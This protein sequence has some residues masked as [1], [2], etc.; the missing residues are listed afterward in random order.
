[1]SGTPI[2]AKATAVWLCDNTTMTFKQI[3]D[4][5]ALHELEVQGIADGDVAVGVKGFDPIANKQLTQDEI[6]RGEANPSHKLELLFHP[7]SSGEEKRRGPRYTPLSKRQDRPASIYWLVKFHPELSDGQISKLV[8]TTKPTIQAI[9]ERTH[10]NINNIEPI[11]PVALGLCK[12]VELDAAVQKAAAKK[13]KEGGVM[14]DDERRKLVSTE[15]SL[16]G[17]TEPKIPSAIEGLET[18]TL[19]TDVEP[20]EDT[21]VPDKDTFFNLPDDAGDDD[22]ED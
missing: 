1:M 6:T 17:D 2:M 10:W 21:S 22:D 8:G 5:C 7:G 18:F 13:L 16:G 3:A 15:Q 20:D 12:Q 19:S 14:N 11:D 9:R 4:F